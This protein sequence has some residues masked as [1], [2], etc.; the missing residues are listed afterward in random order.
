MSN[1]SGTM[2]LVD[3]QKEHL[4]AGKTLDFVSFRAHIK[5]FSG[6]AICVERLK[7]MGLH[8]GLEVQAVGQAPF[9]GPL[10]FRFGNTVLALRSEE[11]KCALIE[12]RGD[13]Q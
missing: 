8:E 4:N 13:R 5:G 12:K 2:N 1:P 6:D 3:L 11:A 10:L 7:E 9:G